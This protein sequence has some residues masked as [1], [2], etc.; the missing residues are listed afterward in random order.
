MRGNPFLIQR[1]TP[2]SSDS[3]MLCQQILD[4]VRAESGSSGITGEQGYFHEPTVLLNT[5]PDMSVQREE[6]FGPVLCA[7]P[8]ESAEEIPPVANETRYGLAASIW[9]RDTSKGLRLAKAL[10]AGAVWVNCFGVFDP[11]LPFGGFKQSGWGRELGQEGV[12]A[13]TELKA[14]TIKL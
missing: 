1:R 4:T 10:N 7:M 13:F 9:T 6:I 5:T 12:E 8:F 2:L 11:N 14:V 3:D